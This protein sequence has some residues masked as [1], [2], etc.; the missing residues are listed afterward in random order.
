LP[1]I[2]IIDENCAPTEAELFLK[3]FD[4]PN[5]YIERNENFKKVGAE[6]GTW[7]PK[8]LIIVRMGLYRIPFPS[9]KISGSPLVKSTMVEATLSP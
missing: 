3:F 4:F 7:R 5:F 8:S 2:T 6:G 1:T 9:R